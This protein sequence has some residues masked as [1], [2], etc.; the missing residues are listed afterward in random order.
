MS[1]NFGAV[2]S[3]IGLGEGDEGGDIRIGESVVKALGDPTPATV[4]AINNPSFA[5]VVDPE[6]LVEDKR[7]NFAKLNLE[8]LELRRDWLPDPVGEVAPLC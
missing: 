1:M 2:H 7:P 8:V 4:V 6:E 5:L 3:D